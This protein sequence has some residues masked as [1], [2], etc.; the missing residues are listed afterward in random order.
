MV[1]T[2]AVESVIVVPYRYRA[3]AGSFIE[4]VHRAQRAG[5]VRERRQHI[6]AA[7]I[8]YDTLAENLRAIR[9]EIGE[10][11]NWIACHAGHPLLPQMRAHLASLTADARLLDDA[12][13]DLLVALSTCGDALGD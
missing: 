6:C 4:A 12:L 5:A 9:H 7:R 3:T 11:R 1:N 2:V 13:T 8:W 10:T